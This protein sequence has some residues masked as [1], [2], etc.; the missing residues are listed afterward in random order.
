[1]LFSRRP[2]YVEMT[3]LLE[4]M[5]VRRVDIALAG[6]PRSAQPLAFPVIFLADGVEAM[7]HLDSGGMVM[8]LPR[9]NPLPM[10]LDAFMGRSAL[11]R[12]RWL[13]FLQTADT[14]VW[15]IDPG[16]DAQKADRGT[17]IGHPLSP[18]QLRRYH[19]PLLLSRYL[20]ARLHTL[21]CVPAG[22]TA[23][24]DAG[25]MRVIRT[26]FDQNYLQRDLD[27]LAPERTILEHGSF[28]VVIASAAELPHVLAEIGRLRELTFQQVG[29]GS[30]QRIDLDEYDAHYLHLF[31]WDRKARAIAGAYRLGPGD[32]LM[33]RFG[34]RG[35]Y[36]HSLF[37][38]RD[39]L[40]PVLQHSLELGRSFVVPAYQQQRLPLFLLWKGIVLWVQRH[41]QY[42]YL[43]GPVSISNSF[44]RVSRSL[45]VQYIYRHHYD[46]NLA[47]H[48]RPRN[49]FRPGFGD[50]DAE[51]LLE[52]DAA[53]WKGLEQ[54][55]ADIEPDR[56]RVPVLLRKYFAQNARIIGFNLDPSFSDA[57]DG[58]MVC[59]VETLQFP[60]AGN[61]D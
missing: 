11:L 8:V 32:E 40:E 12:K 52:S 23:S 14:P 60:V 10:H 17:R 48:V 24:A 22:K 58:F 34:K 19:D 18:Q 46:A 57:L 54:L 35:F 36:L 20:Q 4:R 38:L 2:D 61:G 43:T 51:V 13:R 27:A 33:E 25:W 6:W 45:L 47:A 53:N 1:M 37:H 15:P 42:R 7:Q 29:E 39:E 50:L 59:P 56:L 31:L 30:S 44:S 55:I 9:S 3:D 41:P 21:C 16:R 28:Q 49:A 26:P 5:A